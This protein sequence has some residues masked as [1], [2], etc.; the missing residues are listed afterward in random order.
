MRGWLKLVFVAAFTILLVAP[1]S[2]YGQ[3]GTDRPFK[4]RMAGTVTFEWPGE[5]PSGCAMVTTVT[6]ATGQ[7]TH[8]GLAV[9]TAS[10]C[11]AQPTYANDGRLTLTAANGDM[12]YGTYDYVPGP[13]APTP[14]TWTGGTGRFAGASGSAFM[15]WKVVQQFIPGCNPDP[16]PSACFDFSVPW[17]WSATMTGTVSY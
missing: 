10:H 7:A 3:D 16:T 15:D 1:I 4:A 17:P 11:P 2:A 13:A 8:L 12:L 6:H 9:A 14:V 5:W